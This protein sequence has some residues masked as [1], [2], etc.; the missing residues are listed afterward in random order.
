MLLADAPPEAIHKMI[1]AAKERGGHD[2]ITGVVVTVL[3]LGAEAVPA[4]VENESTQPVDVSAPGWA[5]DESTENISPRDL[6]RLGAMA[7][8]QLSPR[9]AGAA[10]LATRTTVPMAVPSP[11]ELS[12]L[13]ITDPQ[14][15]A[16]V[17][18]PAPASSKKPPI[19]D[20]SV[21]VEGPTLPKGIVARPR[22]TGTDDTG[23]QIKADDTDPGDGT[24]S[25]D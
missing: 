17:D 24:K 22:P 7:G 14:M 15:P 4:V 13:D 21:D 23:P 16:L 1:E 5:D 25:D 11:R 9:K 2:N 10:E 19:G 20:P 12:A 3:E 8:A 6:D 18:A